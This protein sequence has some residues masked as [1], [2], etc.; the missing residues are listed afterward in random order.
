MRRKV[1]NLT[2]FTIGAT[3]GEIG[4]VTE[5]YFDDQTWTV[6]YLIVKTGGWLSGRQVLIAPQAITS[7]DW[8]EKTFHVNLTKGQVKASP[9]IDTSKPV[10]R[11]QELTLYNHYPWGSYWGG[12]LWAG[13]LGTTG[14]MMPINASI[15]EAKENQKDN[16]EKTSNDDPHLRSTDAITGYNIKASDGTIGDVEDFIINDTTWKIDFIEVD[17]GNWF[18]GK[19]VVLSPGLIKEIKWERAEV[20]VNATAEQIKASPEYNAEMHLEDE[21]EA[22]LKDYYERF[23]SPKQKNVGTG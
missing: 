23:V 5:F 21:Y 2:G 9:D 17:T 7:P 6:R 22:V 20:L 4:K 19:K 13:G 18:P 11:Q 8:S 16:A 12:G 1:K 15:E 3:D 14:M 10:S